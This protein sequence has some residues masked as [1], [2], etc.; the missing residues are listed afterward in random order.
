VT[1][2]DRKLWRQLWGLRAQTL[3]IALV[4]ASGIA[5]FVMAV[6]A[7]A[8]LDATRTAFYERYRFAE[9]FATLERA[10]ERLAETIAALP[11]VQ[12]VET[13]VVANADLAVPGFAEPVLGRLVSLPERGAPLL[14]LPHLRIGRMPDPARLDEALVSEAF[15]EAHGLRPGDR[16]FANLEGKRRALTVTGIALSPEFVYVMAPGALLPDDRRYGIVWLPRP[17]LA[18]AFD[19]DGAFNDVTLTLLRGVEPASV[20]DPLDRLLEPYGGAGA[21]ARADQLSHYFLDQELEQLRTIAGLLPVIFL[22]VAVFLLNTVTGRLVA[23]EREAIGVLKAFGYTDGTIALHYVRLVLLMTLP[24]IVLGLAGGVW[25]ARGMTELYTQFFRFPLILLVIEPLPLGG[26]VLVTLAAALAGTAGAVRAASRLAPAEAMRPPVPPSYRGLAWLGRLRLDQPSLM[27]ARHLARFPL[28]AVLSAA[29]IAAAMGILLVSQHFLDAVQT[30]LRHEFETARRY[31][32]AVTFFEPQ[33]E[34]ALLE[35]AGLEGVLAVEPQRQLA[36]RFVS[37]PVRELGVVTG[38]RPGARLERILDTDGT[39]LRV[40]EAGLVLTDVLADKLRV[41]RGDRLT[42][43]VLESRRPTLELHVAAVVETYLGKAAYMDLDA[44]AR[45]LREA[46]QPGEARLAVDPL[47]EADVTQALL[48][49]PD[50]AGVTRRRAFIESFE[51]TIGQMI[52]I[53]VGFY[54]LFASLCVVGVVYNAA[55]I[56]LSERGRE[57]ASLRVLGFSR[58]EVS[59][60]LL[61][62]MLLLTLL[63]LPLGALFGIGLA[64]V[65]TRGIESDL[66]RIPPVIEPASFAFAG[67]V[68]LAAAMASAL[69]VGR[70]IWRLDIVSALKTRE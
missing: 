39:E 54:V 33:H 13:R 34:R 14:N 58:T 18:A 16:L 4:T 19:L 21:R 49:R 59:Y 67:A 63:A 36:V 70:A 51:T 69:V 12:T 30:L 41:G 64:W 50:V 35:L 32:L 62:E 48:D 29:G 23:L 42:V 52:H 43:E 22:A 38:I 27:I 20:I 55:R 66:F 40:P 5:V 6:G 60:I 17:A 44:M 26:V 3:A 61:G 15:A 1:A 47:A 24:G 2:L 65:I 10:P 68:V 31:D 8:S 7:L 11:G 57:L 46:P 28:R 9:I 45:A 25:L 37:G 56:G 53:I